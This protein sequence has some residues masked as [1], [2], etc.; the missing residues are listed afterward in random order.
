MEQKLIERQRKPFV[1]MTAKNFLLFSLIV[2]MLFLMTKSLSAGVA[3]TTQWRQLFNGKDL[4]GWKQV[5]P[6]SHYVEN[7]LLKSKGGMGLLVWQGEK[8]QN[9]IIRVE[10]AMRDS[11]SNSG[12]FIRIPTMPTEE[13]MPVN[14]G[15]EV[16]IDN[17][18][19]KSGEDEYHY[20][21]M[22]YSLTKPLAKTGKPGPQ[23][24]TMEITLDGPR[25]IVYLNGVKVT[26]F[27][28]GD[29]VPAK[30][31]PFEP[32]RG[33]R[34]E[35]GYMGLQNHSDQ[36]VVFFKEVAVRPLKK[37]TK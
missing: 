17:A 31:F 5:G 10:Y 11:N 2:C 27:K 3:D 21:G 28:E 33:P 24:N 12:V 1:T 13:W 15:Y 20:T 35:S 26:D 36:D 37:S 32:E 4:T 6:G 9:C 25:T 8:F 18:P 29:P 30:K 22:L 16:Q 34:P 7:G 14:K 19:E 23:W